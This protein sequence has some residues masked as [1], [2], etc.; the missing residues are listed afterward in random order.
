M[1]L[2]VMK[3]YEDKWNETQVVIKNQKTTGNKL[4]QIRLMMDKIKD[5][6]K[7][8]IEFCQNSSNFPKYKQT[9]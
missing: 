2:R 5:W 4:N 6:D 3:D 8:L 7:M 1:L 9:H